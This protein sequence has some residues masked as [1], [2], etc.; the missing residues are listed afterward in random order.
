MDPG[1]ADVGL[2]ILHR[3]TTV[4]QHHIAGAYGLWLA[5]TMG[6][7][8]GFAQQDEVEFDLAA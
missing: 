8:G 6:I 4:H 3:A 5:G 7:G 1:P 2:I